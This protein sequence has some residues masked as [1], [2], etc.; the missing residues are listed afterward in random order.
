MSWDA[1]EGGAADVGAAAT[2]DAPVDTTADA[3]ADT[4]ADPTADVTADA[5][6]PAGPTRT[7]PPART[8]T[9][10]PALA[11]EGLAFAYPDGRQVLFGVDLT[12]APGERIALVG[13]NGAGKTT[14]LLHLNG[15]LGPTSGGFGVGEI[16]VG[17]VPVR[18]D[19]LGEIRR[20]VGI[21]FQDPDDQ[22]FL[23]TVGRDVAFGPA[24]LGWPSEEVDRRVTGAL[25]RVGLAGLR[26]RT[27]HHLSF[28]QKR[29]VALA[30]VLAMDPDI[31]VLDEPSSNLDPAAR[32]ELAE[33]LTS[34]DVTVVM[35]THD[36]PYAAQLCSRCAILDGGRI[37][38]DGPI[39]DVLSDAEL[40][41]AHRLELP[42]DFRLASPADEKVRDDGAGPGVR[43][44]DGAVARGTAR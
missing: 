43:R 30:G 28:G 27:P 36:L 9:P 5:V 13:P 31:L 29:R 37:V 2:A 23:P 20:R 32:R 10:T 7:P 17:G 6:E 26:D 16:R 1:T 39:L 34:L 41:A 25:E 11:I 42:Y 18:P 3:A 4:T 35:V 8:P 19:T 38:A 12:V 15:T 14:L 21:V 24:N 44:D 40:L 22:L 33:I